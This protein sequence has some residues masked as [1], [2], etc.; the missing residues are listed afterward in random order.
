MSI[1]DG[2]DQLDPAYLESESTELA[3]TPLE[4]LDE[5][6]DRRADGMDPEPTRFVPSE[7]AR[8]GQSA[9]EAGGSVADA[10][11]EEPR[12]PEEIP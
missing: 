8:R 1:D 3:A 4:D 9:D 5:D 10:L 6:V 11:R 2:R 7:A 12:N